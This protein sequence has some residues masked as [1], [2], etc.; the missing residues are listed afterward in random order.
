M[1]LKLVMQLLG[2][3]FYNVD[4]NN[5]PGLTMTYFTASLNLVVC[6]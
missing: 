2:L 6:I 3:K 1:T 5:D 4:M